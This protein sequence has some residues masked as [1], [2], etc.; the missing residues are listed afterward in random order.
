M[1]GAIGLLIGAFVGL[2]RTRRRL[3]LEN[4]ACHSPKLRESLNFIQATCYAA[5]LYVIHSSCVLNIGERQFLSTGLA[6]LGEKN[7]IAF[8]VGHCI[9]LQAARKRGGQ[10]DRSGHP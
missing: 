3:L 8:V 4:L 6:L 10:H 5:S 9:S 2:L 7:V 1:I